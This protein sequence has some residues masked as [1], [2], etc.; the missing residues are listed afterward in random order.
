MDNNYNNIPTV[1]SIQGPTANEIPLLTELTLQSV[2]DFKFNIDRAKERYQSSNIRY[3]SYIDETTT[4]KLQTFATCCPSIAKSNYP[5][6]SY[7]TCIDLSTLPDETVYDIL[8]MRILPRTEDG[9]KEELLKSSGK[10]PVFIDTL[11]H[12][13]I[14]EWYEHLVP[15]TRHGKSWHTHVT[16]DNMLREN[17]MLELHPSTMTPMV[18]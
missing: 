17:I 2:M 8:L 5:G 1:V 4:L 13:N 9:V 16:L 11:D 14:E 6:S 15:S 7:T 12:S 10:F 3:A 18:S